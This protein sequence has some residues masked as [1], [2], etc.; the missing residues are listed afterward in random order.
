MT[1]LVLLRHGHARSLREA[2]VPADSLR[3]LSDLGEKEVMEAAG[4]LK[5]EGF[6]PGLI[7]SSPF[8]RAVRTAELAASLWPSAKRGTS[9]ALSD[10]PVQEILDLAAAESSVLLVGHQPLLGMTAGFLAG[11]AALDLSPAGYA[12]LRLENGAPKARLLEMYSPGT[13]EGKPR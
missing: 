11:E 9:D 13:Q 12:R 3:P 10:G 1:D 7:I 8:T 6:S 2:G 5:A 4:R